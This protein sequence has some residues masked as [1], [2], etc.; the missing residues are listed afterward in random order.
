MVFP[1]VYKLIE[2]AL[3][4]PLSTTF[5]QRLLSTTNLFNDWFRHSAKSNTRQ[6][7]RGLPSVRP[8]H[9]ETGPSLPSRGKDTRQNRQ[10]GQVPGRGHSAN[11]P[12]TADL[13]SRLLFFAPTNNTRQSFFCCYFFPGCR[14]P[15]VT[16][17][18]PSAH[19]SRQ[20]KP[21]LPVVQCF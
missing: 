11:Q 16:R 7:W 14:L 20:S 19:G 21:P 2:L 1:L 9:S 5:V 13:P 8:A 10:V 3:L 18:S 17:P 15:S 4:V 6:T 12:L